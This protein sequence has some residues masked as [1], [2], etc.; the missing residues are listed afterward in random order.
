MLQSTSDKMFKMVGLLGVNI[1][2]MA[3]EEYVTTLPGDT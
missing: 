3:S 2:I 1:F